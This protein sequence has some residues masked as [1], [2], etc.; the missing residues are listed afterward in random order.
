[1]SRV[2]FCIM[3][4]AL[5]MTLNTVNAQAQ[6]VAA[7]KAAIQAALDRGCQGF[8][9]GD[10]AAAMSPYNKKAF[11][12]DLSP[13]LNSNYDDV[14]QGNQKLVAVLDGKPTCT[15]K[16]VV[17]KIDHNHAYVHYLLPFTAKLKGGKSLDVVE[18][19]TDIFELTNGKWLIVHEHASVPVDIVAEKLF[20]RAKD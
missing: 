18:R 8:I 12:F 6:T 19:V 15:Y 2:T 10:V 14:L 5:A 16:E 17:I 1:M 11:V 20:L 13:K 4:G 7:H 3:A 9:N